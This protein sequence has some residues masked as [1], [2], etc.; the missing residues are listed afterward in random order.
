MP[1]HALNKTRNSHVFLPRKAFHIIKDFFDS[2]LIY[3]SILNE[4]NL[5]IFVEVD[6]ISR[7]IL[8]KL[9][10]IDSLLHWL[11]PLPKFC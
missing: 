10:G 11:V 6:T 1:V 9:F 8:D 5:L 4:P 7:T 3:R 2:D